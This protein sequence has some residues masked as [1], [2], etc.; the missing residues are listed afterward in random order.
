MS[1]TSHIERIWL[2]IHSAWTIYHV[3]GKHSQKW[4]I[5]NDQEKDAVD[6][7]KFDF[8]F[9]WFPFKRIKLYSIN[10]VDNCLCDF[11]IDNNLS[12]CHRTLVS[13]SLYW[14]FT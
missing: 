5:Q 7:F 1:V 3:H 12:K 14:G 9:A 8:S 10:K 6:F 11:I 13:K 2:K 4:S